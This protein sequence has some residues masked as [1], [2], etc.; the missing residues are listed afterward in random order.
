MPS[1]LIATASFLSIPSTSCF[2]IRWRE[3][4]NGGSYSVVP[5]PHAMVKFTCRFT[6]RPVIDLTFRTCRRSAL[7]LNL[8]EDR[9]FQRLIACLGIAQQGV[10]GRGWGGGPANRAVFFI[11]GDCHN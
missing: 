4:K 9:V 10:M 7:Q 3:A 5:P 11:G 6:G 2:Q 1:A 8:R